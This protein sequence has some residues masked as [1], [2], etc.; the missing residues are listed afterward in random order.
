[1]MKYDIIYLKLFSLSITNPSGEFMLKYYKFGLFFIVTSLL[2]YLVG[3]LVSPVQYE[4]YF[5]DI[6][7]L[8]FF[9]GLLLLVITFFV[10]LWNNRQ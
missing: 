9:I 4:N 7:Y 6:S 5:V 10:S 3:L 2:V 1:M 8:T